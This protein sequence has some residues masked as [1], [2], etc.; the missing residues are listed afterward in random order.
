MGDI[1][2]DTWG[3]KGGQGVK[4]C[5]GKGGEGIEGGKTHKNASKAGGGHPKLGK[6]PKI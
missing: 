5:E 4:A 6:G 1:R 2:G 3:E